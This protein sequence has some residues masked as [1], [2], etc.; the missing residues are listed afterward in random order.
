MTSRIGTLHLDYKANARD[1]AAVAMAPH[2]D[3]LLANRLADAVDARLPALLGDDRE[4]I[5]IKEVHARASLR[6]ADLS[7]DSRVV[8]AVGRS[9]LDAIATVLA[10][11][12][13]E[14][15]IVRFADQAEFIGAFI[16]DVLRGSAWDRWYF[17]AF[18]RYHRG[19]AGETIGAVL[20]DQPEHA[21][22]VFGW[23][24]RRGHLES[25]LAVL[26]TDRAKQLAMPRAAASTVADGHDEI[27]PL[28]AA[29]FRLVEALGWNA[30]DESAR[31]GLAA[32][33]LQTQPMVPTW[34]DRRSLTAWVL[35]FLH[36]AVAELTRQRVERRSE[37]IGARELLNN[38]L[39]W[40]DI[41]WMVPQIDHLS[42]PAVAVS[43]PPTRSTRR[44]LT[45]RHERALARLAEAIR[46]G[47]VGL[48]AT[49]D[50]DLTALRLMA[51]HAEDERSP[52][53]PDRAL[54]QA[55]ERIVRALKAAQQ[56][57]YDAQR[58]LDL[59]ERGAAI[60]TPHSGAGASLAP[61]IDSVVDMGPAAQ[62]VLRRLVAATVVAGAGEATAAA[63][64]F[65]IT[66]AMLDVRLHILAGDE[67]VPFE[68]LKAGLAAQWLD[69]KPPFD[70]AAAVWIGKPADGLRPVE[71]WTTSLLKLE[72]RLTS[73]LIQQHAI[74]DVPPAAGDPL[75]RVAALVLRAWSRWLPGIGDSS[76]DFLVRHCLRR[77]A[78][79]RLTATDIELQIQSAPLDVVLEMAGYF[80]P[81]ERVPWLDGRTVT[82]V[83]RRS[84]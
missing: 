21:A 29:A 54:S 61:L 73:L 36:F 20:D 6:S 18:H 62:D 33:Y 3:R 80:R 51:A 9:T 82:F 37:S 48:A 57:G 31:R 24:A 83:R 35:R 58:L 56:S 72:E 71:T 4:V 52:G 59:I 30:G 75:D 65:L 28:I 11:P 22:A 67:Q 84:A 17:G 77:P 38:E 1:R 53:G 39:D 25:V 64:L 45:G 79:A 7:L 12:A 8:E 27:A 49:D 19:D 15:Q 47:R 34:T 81:I 46:V 74:P 44:V 14:E 78:W 13:S 60:A 40:L 10:A 69:V 76:R 32:V 23:L 68:S 42:T 55:I 2:L 26:G 66:R 41:D 50:A 63:G 16:V 5:V 70:P 43:S